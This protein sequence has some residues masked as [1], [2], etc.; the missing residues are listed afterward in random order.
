VEV[1]K[2]PEARLDEGGVGGPVLMHSRKPLSRDAN[3]VEIN[4]ESTYAD[5]TE[6]SEPQVT[7]LY[8][9]NNEADTFAVFCGYTSQTRTN[10][11]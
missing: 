10:R 7:A 11:S 9:V 6:E 3:S 2:S 5:V 8:S 1:Y 4:I